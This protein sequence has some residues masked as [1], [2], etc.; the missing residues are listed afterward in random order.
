MSEE[1]K[2]A[3]RALRV[4][5]SEAT[6]RGSPAGGVTPPEYAP[7]I[8]TPESRPLEAPDDFLELPVVAFLACLDERATDD[9]HDKHGHLSAGSEM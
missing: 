7:G 1:L 5:A 2:L 6:M 4:W 3:P 9:G 8:P